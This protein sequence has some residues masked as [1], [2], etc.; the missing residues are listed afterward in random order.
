MVPILLV[1]FTALHQP[2]DARSFQL[3]FD[4]S[5]EYIEDFSKTF[6]VIMKI[7]KTSGKVVEN[8]EDFRES[9]EDFKG[10]VEFIREYVENLGENEKN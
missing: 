1:L 8:V 7:V 9:V 6:K 3:N 5:L 10:N 4:Q 2:T